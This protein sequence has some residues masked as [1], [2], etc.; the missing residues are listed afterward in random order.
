MATHRK[1][2]PGMKVRLHGG[3]TASTGFLLLR[4][5][6]CDVLGG[7]VEQLLREWRAARSRA[8][9]LAQGFGTSA[10]AFQV[11]TKAVCSLSLSSFVVNTQSR[12]CADCRH[13]SS[14]HK[15]PSP[16]PR[17]RSLRSV[18]HHS[19][20]SRRGSRRTLHRRARATSQRRSP[21]SAPLLPLQSSSSRNNNR[22]SR[23]LHQQ[24]HRQCS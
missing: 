2:V 10:P 3:V 20:S 22:G 24:P 14:S 17:A 13:L 19:R 1:L 7:H 6:T 21:R 12:T 16:S 9:A 23:S 8:L 15:H 5:N 18:Q 11:L 4:E